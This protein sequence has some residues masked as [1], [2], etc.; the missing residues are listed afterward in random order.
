MKIAC[1]GCDATEDMKVVIVNAREHHELPK[2][3][4]SIAIYSMPIRNRI[5]C[6]DC[7]SNKPLADI[8]PLP[9]TEVAYH[10]ALRAVHG[11]PESPVAV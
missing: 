4:V 8:V 9:D 2:G 10:S 5:L 3:W 11:A 6:P 1:Q 7:L